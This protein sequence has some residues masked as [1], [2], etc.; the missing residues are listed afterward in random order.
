MVMST[1]NSTLSTCGAYSTDGRRGGIFHGGRQV[2]PQSHIE[3][4][5]QYCVPYRRRPYR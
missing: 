4:L 2:T 3:D 1:I 5:I